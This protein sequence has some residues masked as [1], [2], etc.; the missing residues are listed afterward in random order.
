M[1]QSTT[2]L[3]R[4]ARLRRGRPFWIYGVIALA[5]VSLCGLLLVLKH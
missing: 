5:G 2:R 3:S 1:I 4:G